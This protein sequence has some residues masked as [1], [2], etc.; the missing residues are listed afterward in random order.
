MTLA[1]YQSRVTAADY[2]NIGGHRPHMLE[3]QEREGWR[4]RPDSTPFRMGE[5]ADW[6]ADPFDDPNWFSQFHGWRPMDVYLRAYLRSGDGTM[7]EK[8]LGWALAWPAY[9]RRAPKEKWKRL[10][11]LSGMR[12][13]RLALLVDAHRRGDVG[14]S[15]EGWHT[16]RGLAAETAEHL[17]TPE[18]I[19]TMNH[20]YFQALGLELLARVFEEED[21]SAPARERADAAFNDLV[22]VQFT[23]EGVHVENSPAYHWYAINQIHRSE[24]ATRLGSEKTRE[25]I[26][27]AEAAG[28]WL[29]FPDG[30]IA[31]IGDSEGPGK[32]FEDHGG[33]TVDVAGKTF[34][35]APFWRS[36]YGIV[37]SVPETPPEEASMLLFVGASLSHI[38]S[39]ADKLSF[40]LYEFGRRLLVDSGKYGYVRDPMRT[41]VE[42]AVA[43]NTV[44]LEDHDL[45]RTEVTLGSTRLSEPTVEDDVIVLAGEIEWDTRRYAFTHRRQVTYRPRR[46]LVIRDRV[47]SEHEQRYASRL[48][49]AHTLDVRQ[50]EWGLLADL[51][52]GHAMRVTATYGDI[53]L[54][55]GEDDP[56]RGW[57]SVGYL[58]M[59]P[60]TMAEVVCPGRE[61]ELEWRITFS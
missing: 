59:E 22:A 25:T 26:R 57:Q 17:M 40:E 21:W 61:V 9:R 19:Q 53:A 12:A 5:S 56:P 41:Y 15:A 13:T 47:A 55:K 29:T 31:D 44:G 50:D 7:L 8:P 49:F 37:R 14:L 48:H 36:G 30:R 27:R 46:S 54:H 6:A 38:H 24:A 52:D 60:A 3:L 45:R 2:Y 23:D 34:A 4:A 58:A 1:D 51:G 10:D 28:P 35:L 18:G 32:A 11:A 42:S 39:H 43:H 16:L 20:G 33:S